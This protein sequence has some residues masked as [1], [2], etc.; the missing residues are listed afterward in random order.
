MKN[1]N[2]I[3]IGIITFHWGTNYGGVLQSY[4]LQTFLEKKGFDVEIINYAKISFRD[5]FWRCFRVRKLN[6]VFSNIKNYIKEKNI[7][8]FRKDNLNLTDRYHSLDELQMNTLNFDCIITG[9]DQVW[10]PYGIS[11]HGLVY[12]L[13]FGRACAKKIAYAPSLGCVDYP[14]D[15]MLKIKPLLEDFN[16]IS[17]RENS[18]KSILK[19][20][21]FNN[22]VLMPDPTLLIDKSDYLKFIKPKTQESKKYCFFYTLQPNQSLIGSINKLISK[23]MDIVN[24][25][26]TYTGFK[27]IESW[28]SFI[29]NSDFVVTNSFHGVIFS[30]LL[31]KNFIVTPIEGSLNGMNDRIYTLLDQFDLRERLIEKYDEGAILKYMNQPIDF[32]NFHKIQ[33]TLRNKALMFFNDN[34]K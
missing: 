2:N 32:E 18:G 13:P 4:A 21:G 19:N 6:G 8:K 26:D 30:L 23:K 14:K 16:A 10:N 3:K 15:I 25:L 20:N 31:N 24:T 33:N 7:D 1:H 17:V 5:S 22:V 12:F 11:S 28:L 34:L 9:S 27:G 29:N